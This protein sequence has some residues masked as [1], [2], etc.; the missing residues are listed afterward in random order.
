MDQHTEIYSSLAYPALVNLSLSSSE[1]QPTSVTSAYRYTNGQTTYV[2]FD[3]ATIGSRPAGYSLYGSDSFNVTTEAETSGPHTVSFE[4]PSVSDPAVF[5]TLRVLH[6]ETDQADPSHTIWVDRTVLS[7]DAPAPDFT[8]RTINARVNYLGAFVIATASAQPPAGAADVSVR[9]DGSSDPV[10]AG[11]ELTYTLTVDNSGPQP[12]TEVTLINGLSPQVDFVSATS[13]SGTC[14]QID[15]NVTCKL[16]PI[17]AGANAI[18]TLVVKPLENRISFPPAG[19]K[20][21]HT[22]FVR[23]KESDGTTANNAATKTTTVLPDPNAAPTVSITSPTI[24]ARFVGPANITIAST[25]T[26]SNGTVS[27]VD[28]FDNGE[29]LGTATSVGGGQYSFAWTNVGFGTHALVARATDNSGREKTSSPVNVSVNGPATVNISSPVAGVVFNRP[30]N[31][32]VTGERELQRRERQRGSI[33][34]KRQLD[35]YRRCYRSRSIRDYVEQCAH[36]K[37]HVIS[38]RYR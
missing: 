19:I 38:R 18:V 20:I 11:T 5:A 33:L 4:L 34:C 1:D 28:L 37:L 9:I 13:T 7:P 35:R 27:K 32:A 22:A 29:L 36:R 17:N 14:K 25:A 8:G 16:T 2:P 3:P 24:G 30:A 23:A 26:D 6:A 31:I 12:A 10:T 15:G 21:S